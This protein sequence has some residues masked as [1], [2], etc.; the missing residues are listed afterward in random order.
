MVRAFEPVDADGVAT[1][2]DHLS[3]PS[4]ADPA[5]ALAACSAPGV[6]AVVAVDGP[7]VVGLAQ[8]FGDGVVQSFL[9]LLG[10]HADHRRRGIAHQ[11]V[12]A[13]YAGT[14][15]RRM[16]LLAD[17]VTEGAEEFYRSFPHYEKPGFRIYPGRS[18]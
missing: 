12:E 17:E 5:V 4:Y 1:L 8:A 14:G 18:A 15:T 7:L 16:D 11:L 9:A 13:A 3:W 10:V 2:C 6:V